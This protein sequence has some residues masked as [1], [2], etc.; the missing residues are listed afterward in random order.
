[1]AIKS[2]NHSFH[3]SIPF[4]LNSSDI[5]EPREMHLEILTIL[6]AFDIPVKDFWLSHTI[7]I[8]DGKFAITEGEHQNIEV[9]RQIFHEILQSGSFSLKEKAIFY[10]K[11]QEFFSYEI[12]SFISNDHLITAHLVDENQVKEEIDLPIDILT[13]T[14]F[15][16][17]L[18]LKDYLEA[19]VIEEKKCPLIYLPLT[20]SAKDFHNYVHFKSSLNIEELIK[21]L[22]L[23]DYLSDEKTAQTCIDHI[24]NY[25]SMS[26]SLLLDLL[27][28]LPLLSETLLN[29]Y[30]SLLASAYI[31]TATQERTSIEEIAFNL[32]IS[33]KELRLNL[34]LSNLLLTSED[35]IVLSSSL[36]FV[37][38]LKLSHTLIT[39]LPLVWENSLEVLDVSKSLIREIPKGF[40]ALKSFNGSGAT[41]LYDLAFL[42][43]SQDLQ[44]INISATSISRAP[45]NCPNLE[46]F[47]ANRVPQLNDI[48]SLNDSKHLKRIE[49][50]YTGVSIA[51]RGC[52]SLEIFQACS[53]YMQDLSGL[54]SLSN[55]KC[56][57]A[58]FSSIRSAPIECKSL[59]FFIADNCQYLE[60]IEGLSN[61]ENLKQIHVNYSKI[62]KAP[63]GCLH[64]EKFYALGAANLSDLSG[65]DD[66]E[67]LE[68]LSIPF[69]KVKCA[70]SGCIQL[71]KFDAESAQFLENITG[72]KD[73]KNLKKIVLK[74]TKIGSDR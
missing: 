63:Y 70:P 74:G 16:D 18:L 53:F 41:H 5:Q 69:T 19:Q 2:T 15:F 50:D 3:P 56:I 68:E 25:P 29:H 73:S 66:L 62:T 44:F 52:S 72:L 43:H 7:S 45:I 13:R 64:L 65:L 48:S 57:K 1:M 26:G 31:N 17:H 55:L 34:D 39:N 30:G 35:L 37:S 6:G 11:A 49:I 14:P 8:L 28:D 58:T 36:P 67:K 27:L 61:L 22:I 32:S 33:V 23:A 51:P 42:D 71:V 38:S 59:E 46:I 12:D 10:T 4:P 60:D 9:I 24:F 21:V 54:N 20:T 47:I 40:N